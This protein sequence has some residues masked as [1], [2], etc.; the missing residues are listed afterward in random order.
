[1]G[2]LKSD[3]S[4]KSQISWLSSKMCHRALTRASQVFNSPQMV[5]LQLRMWIPAAEHAYIYADTAAHMQS[6]L[7]SQEQVS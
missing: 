3:M 7:F 2:M 5:D 4:Y 6:S 1:M